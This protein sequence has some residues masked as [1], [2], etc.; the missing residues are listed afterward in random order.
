M[1]VYKTRDAVYNADGRLYNMKDI[2]GSTHKKGDGFQG[3][4]PLGGGKRRTFSGKTAEAVDM[5]MLAFHL[6]TQGKTDITVIPEHKPNRQAEAVDGRSIRNM[7]QAVESCGGGTVS[8]V[9]DICHRWLKNCCYGT[10]ADK[11]FSSYEQ[12]IRNYIKPE[13][14]DIFV[15]ELSVDNAIKMV[16]GMNNRGLSDRT[17]RYAVDRLVS[18]LDYAIELG[19]AVRNVAKSNTLGQI[20]RQMG[21]EKQRRLKSEQLTGIMTGNVKEKALTLDECKKI[22]DYASISDDR[23]GIGYILSMC[24]GFRRGEVLGLQWDSVHMD[25]KMIFIIQDLDRVAVYDEE[26]LERKGT[27]L[28][29]GDVKTVD[30]LRV[31]FISEEAVELLNRHKKII[32]AEK[33]RYGDN[34]TDSGY[35]ICT[36]K[37]TPMEP[38]N[39]NRSFGYAI[40][41]MGITGHSPHN[42]RATFATEL[43]AMDVDDRVRKALMG[44]STKSETID[45]YTMLREEYIKGEFNKAG[46]VIKCL[47][48]HALKYN[49]DK[50]RV[51]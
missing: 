5:K 41:K 1:A 44:H 15:D 45:I 26:T 50:Y 8:T 23:C 7:T 28:K 19:A 6:G 11:T 39:F 20:M 27:V 32:D 34:Y 12:T 47:L 2:P 49:V 14:G 13:L 42:L 35:V 25:K 18:V 3:T 30:S 48:D 22:I 24:Y 33:E 9:G 16:H 29:P 43:K 31:M 21:K 4:Y 17:V 51:N 36:K 46:E 38:R 10:V 37:G 40:Q